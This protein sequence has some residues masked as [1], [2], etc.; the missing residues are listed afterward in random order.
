MWQLLGL[1]SNDID[2]ALSTMMGVAFAEHLVQF[3]SQ[4]GHVMREATTIA[5]NPDQSKHLETAM[6]NVLGLDIDLV[7]LRSEV[8]AEGSRIPSEVVCHFTTGTLCSRAHWLQGV[9]H[10]D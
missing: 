3:M 6:V 8:Y 9:W 2:V 4:R 10:S 1:N 7:N 5:R